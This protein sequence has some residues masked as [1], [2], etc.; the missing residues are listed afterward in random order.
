MPR[1]PWTMLPEQLIVDSPFLIIFG[2]VFRMLHLIF[3]STHA[4][5]LYGLR[6]HLCCDTEE[7]Y[8]IYTL[9][10][11][12]IG[13][14][15]LNCR[16]KESVSFSDWKSFYSSGPSFVSCCPRLSPSSTSCIN[17]SN[18]QTSAITPHH[19]LRFPVC[20]HLLES[21]T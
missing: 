7:E 12:L 16:S 18:F 5:L 20:L 8:I 15:P 19:F 17:L 2:L 14:N 1:L 4:I 11:I 3:C 6:I 10:G 13:I 21:P 9:V